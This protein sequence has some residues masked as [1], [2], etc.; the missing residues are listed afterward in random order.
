MSLFFPALN[1]LRLAQR[2]RFRRVANAVGALVCAAL[3]ASALFLQHVMGMEPCPLC[4]FQR[5]AVN[6]TGVLFLLAALHNPKGF[7]ARVYGVLIAVAGLAGIGVAA[8]HIWIQAQPAGSVVACGADLSYLLQM[9]PITDV[10]MRV[11][12]GAGECSK[13]QWTL[14]GL[15]MPWWVAIALGTLAAAGIAINFARCGVE[16]APAQIEALRLR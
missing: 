12:T 2:S 13:V 6:A 11:L 4:V 10:V 16:R 15:S 9:L 7:G 1:E 5:M 14:L 3:I 8:R